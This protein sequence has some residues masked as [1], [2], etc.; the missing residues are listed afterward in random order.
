MKTILLL[1]SNYPINTRNE[2]ILYSLSRMDDCIV[3]VCT[4]N[5]NSVPLNENRDYFVYKKASA[6]GNLRLKLQNLY[7]FYLFIKKEVLATSRYDV[8]IASH[9]DML[10]LAFLLKNKNQVLI[11]ENL[12]IPTSSNLLLL[13]FLQRI[14][15]MCLRKTDAIVFASRFFVDL[16]SYFEG[17]KFLIENKPLAV[18]ANWCP[19]KEKHN[20]QFVIS[21]IGLVRYWDIL[22]H[23]VDA[24]RGN[25]AV[26]L[27]IHGEGQD[28]VRLQDYA[29]G[30]ANIHFTGRYEQCDLPVLYGNSDVVWA[31]YPNK[32]HNVKYAISNKFHES[33]AY[34]TPC[35]FSDKTKLGDFVAKNKIGLVVNPY[36]VESIKKM[37]SEIVSED[38]ILRNLRTNLKT[39]SR[40]EKKW[41]EEIADLKEYISSL[42]F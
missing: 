16:Y 40:T 36:S 14:E 7:G 38:G 39:F 25:T 15:R 32:D 41:E 42:N 23:L 24:V 3:K 22:Q 35:I 5:R 10:F 20:M 12:D 2:K 11:Y 30:C 8:I 9:W 17:R 29:K 19:P 18:A 27:N 33:I 4:W 13:Y 21:Y 28:L 34:E 26:V 6:V 1:D 31:A 37:M